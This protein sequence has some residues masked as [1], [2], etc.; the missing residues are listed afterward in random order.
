MEPFQHVELWAALVAQTLALIWGLTRYMLK[1]ER[2][3][4]RIELALKLKGDEHE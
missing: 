1:I 2:R 3:L 4:M